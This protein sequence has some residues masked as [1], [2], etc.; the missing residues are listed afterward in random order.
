MTHPCLADPPD[1]RRIGRAVR[2]ELRNGPL[3]G[4]ELHTRFQATAEQAGWI[5]FAC[6][7][8]AA[9]GRVLIDEHGTR[10]IFRLTRPYREIGW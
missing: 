4:R 8:E 3:S 9:A 1:F 2:R 6:G 5:G 10:M 7:I